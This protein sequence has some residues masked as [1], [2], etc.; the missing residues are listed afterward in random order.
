MKTDVGRRYA[1]IM[2]SLTL[3]KSA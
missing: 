1:L 2:Q 3:V